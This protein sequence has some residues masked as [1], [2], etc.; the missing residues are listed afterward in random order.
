MELNE[1]QDLASKTAVYPNIGSRFIYPTLGLAGE[2]GEVT[3]K[4]KKIFR[5]EEGVLNPQRH[6]ELKKELGDVLWYVSQLARDLNLKL[7][8]IA[9]DNI[10]KLQKR[11]QLNM[12]SGS[13]DN[14]EELAA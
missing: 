3:N 5:D 10:A 7:D 13:G 9:Q 12:L 11:Q 14:R 2:V 1:Y 8:D 6:E 4:I